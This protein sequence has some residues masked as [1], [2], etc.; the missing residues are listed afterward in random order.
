MDRLKEIFGEKLRER[1]CVWAEGGYTL[2]FRIDPELGDCY[3]LIPGKNTVLLSGGRESNLFAALG[4]FM[5]ES[6]FDG[7][8]GFIPPHCSLHHAYKIQLRGI[9]F[10]THFYNY[11]HEAPLDKIYAIIA[12]M[13][14]RGCNSLLVWFDMH[15]Y[16]GIHSEKAEK[17][18]ERLKRILH[19]AESVGIEPSLLML[20]NEGFDGTPETVRAE[21]RIQN[22]YTSLMAGF[23][24]TEICPSKQGGTEEILRQRREVLEAFSDIRLKYFCIWPYDQGGCNCA[25]CAPWGI[26]GYLKLLS[27]LK[28]VI[29]SVFPD[30]E[31]ILSTWFFDRFTSGEWE[32]ILKRIKTKKLPVKPEYIMTYFFDE[33]PDAIKENGLP[34]E[35]KFISFPEISMQGASPW[36]GFGANPLPNFLNKNSFPEIYRGGFPYSEGIFED[37]NKWVCLR[38]YSGYRDSVADSVREYLKHEFCCS[39]EE[40]AEAVLRMENTLPRNIYEDN[41]LLHCDIASPA[42]VFQIYETVMKYD[43]LLPEKLRLGWK[44]RIIF[45]RAVIDREL[46]IHR[47]IPSSSAECQARFSELVR[48]YY[49]DHANEYVKPPLGK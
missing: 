47:G 3:S 39:S 25:E 20:A 34:E 30:A 5:T 42:H 11:Y 41:G 49:A 38:A 48:L 19:Y 14:L 46:V 8:G 17:M 16:S 45:C 9:Y 44:W 32:G 13:A 40:L 15:H 2:E 37:I 29:K 24:N 6:E 4:R 33:L 36:G 7:R 1:D 23:Y 12:D 26:N 22:G 35:I 43:A 31:L 18:T 21:N 10:A 28:N 27:G